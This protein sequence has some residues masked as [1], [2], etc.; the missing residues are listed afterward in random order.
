MTIE[1]GEAKLCALLPGV[2]SHVDGL[3][4]DE[5]VVRIDASTLVTA[6]A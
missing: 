2:I 1:R 5:K 4:S 3:A 6:M